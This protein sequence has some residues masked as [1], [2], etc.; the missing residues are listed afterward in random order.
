VQNGARVAVEAQLHAY[1]TRHYIKVR[2]QLRGLAV[3]PSG[4][5]CLVPLS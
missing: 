4:Q 3:L 5:H 1:E 2:G